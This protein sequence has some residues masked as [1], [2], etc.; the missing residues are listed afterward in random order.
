[1]VAALQVVDLGLGVQADNRL[2]RELLLVFRGLRG[3]L[4]GSDASVDGKGR[5][6]AREEGANRDGGKESPD[7]GRLLKGRATNRTLPARRFRVT[8][9]RRSKTF[10]ANRDT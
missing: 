2:A 3:D 1:M 4:E 9:I 5:R 6:G 8:L 10:E 7:P